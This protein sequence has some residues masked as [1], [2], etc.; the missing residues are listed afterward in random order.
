MQS[1]HTLMI[2]GL[3][4]IALGA[5]SERHVAAANET[6]LIV[7]ENVERKGDVGTA[8]IFYTFAEPPALDQGATD[9]A[10]R[11]RY[12]VEFDCRAKAWGERLQEMTM[13][14]GRSFTNRYPVA[15]LTQ[16]VQGTLGGSIQAA[17]CGTGRDTST[18]RPRRAIEKSYLQK[19]DKRGVSEAAN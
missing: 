15:R 16:R 3:A 4:A 11:M 12:E 19:V 1:C 10:V 7:V 2:A 8:E 9:K 13:A 6:A 14:D 17:L 18:R 5:C